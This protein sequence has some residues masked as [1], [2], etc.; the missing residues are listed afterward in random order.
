MWGHHFFSDDED[1]M[2]IIYYI[3]ILLML[4]I[5]INNIKLTPELF[6]IEINKIL[7]NF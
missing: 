4:N 2:V 3:Y 5:R 6:S 7:F 1:F